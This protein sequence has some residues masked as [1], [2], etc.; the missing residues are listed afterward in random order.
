M[1]L[2]LPDHVV[3]DLRM[4]RAAE[5]AAAQRTEACEEFNV[6]LRRMDPHLELVWYPENARAAQGFV[7]GR[8]HL[9]RHNPD[10]SGSVEPL[11]DEVGGFREPDS[12]IYEWL[13]RSDMWND[14]AMAERR[15]I[16]ARAIDAR[17]AAD[18]RDEEDR[19]AELVDR[20]N[21]AWRATVSMDSDNAW[22]QNA[23]GKRGAVGGKSKLVLP[24]G[25]DPD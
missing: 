12:S 20:A 23:A 10:A 7:R 19:K 3:R 15:R 4:S 6:E 1:P 2:V 25:V 22:S 18:R 5:I 21:A 17:C 8:Y 24:D 14:R 13:A 16:T 9:I 11:V